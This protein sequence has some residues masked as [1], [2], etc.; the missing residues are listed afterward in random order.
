MTRSVPE[1][2]ELD[3]L[4]VDSSLLAI[5]PSDR[6][7]RTGFSLLEV[8][9]ATAVLAGSA[10]VLMS[11]IG[12]GTRYGSKAEQRSLALTVAQTVLDEFLIDQTDFAESD[13]ISGTVEGLRTLTYRLTISD[14]AGEDKSS[15]ASLAGLKR[16][17]IDVFDSPQVATGSPVRPLCRL[18]RLVFQRQY[19]KQENDVNQEDAYGR[20]LLDD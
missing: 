19:P 14:I 7:Q 2:V 4:A 11:L 16:I 15:S 9:I 10:M 13:Q 12:I 6:W 3:T 8:I 20:G 1:S 5:P 17:T 18:T